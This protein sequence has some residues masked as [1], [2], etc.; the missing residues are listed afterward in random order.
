MPH[1]QIISAGPLCT[2]QDLGRRQLMRYGVNRAGAMDALA[3]HACWG[4]LS[5]APD[6]SPLI[7]VPLGGLSVS[8]DAPVSVAVTSAGFDITL[9]GESIGAC[10]RVDLQPEDRLT[11]RAGAAGRYAYLGLAARWSLPKVLGAWATHLRSG[12]GPAAALTAGDRF[13]FEPAALLG[14]AKKLPPLP[15][16]DG[17]LRCIDGPQLDRF[18]EQAVD[19]FYAQDWRVGVASDRM[20]SSLEGAPLG[21]RDSADIVSDGIALGSVQVPG[22]GLPLVLMS[23]CGTTG[24]YAKIAAVIGADLPRLAQARPGESLRFARSDLA[25]AQAARDAIGAALL[26]WLSAREVDW[27]SERLLALN[28]VDGVVDAR[29]SAPP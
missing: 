28:L 10:A 12:V 9:N 24:G 18:D 25:A 2:F 8:A 26:Q 23:D 21:H 15:Y 3:A 29:D 19:A 4:L 5:Q 17:P 16:P 27:S 11:V 7:E 1:L 13:E 20:A 6:A 22:N 14:D